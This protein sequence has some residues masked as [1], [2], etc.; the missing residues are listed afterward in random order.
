MIQSGV[1]EAHVGIQANVRRI[2]LGLRFR[3]VRL[4]SQIATGLAVCELVALIFNGVFN[5]PPMHFMYIQEL[6]RK[7]SNYLRKD[8]FQRTNPCAG[9][10][11]TVLAEHRER[12]WYENGVGN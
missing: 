5:F 10:A 2:E 3:G 1:V 4:A 7:L 6:G 8:G 12:G 11:E 9:A